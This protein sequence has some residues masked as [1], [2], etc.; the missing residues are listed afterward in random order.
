MSTTFGEAT[1][2]E[3]V[4]AAYKDEIRGKNVVITGV[5]P[6][7]LG[8]GTAAAL[9]PYAK[10]IICT[11]RSV[12]RAKDG[13]KDAAALNG[14]EL[15][16]VE[17]DL[18]SGASIRK[19]AEEIKSFGLPIHV[20]I[21]NAG[22]GQ[23]LELTRT[24]EGFESQIGGN[25][26]GHYLFTSL[27]FPS[28]LSPKTESFRPRIINLSSL[29]I[30]WANGLRADDINFEKR[31]EEYTVHAAYAQSKT[32]NIYFS[33]S[34]AEKYGKEG[35]LSYSV[36]PGLIR[37]T[38]MGGV[39]SDQDLKNIGL[40]DANDKPTVFFK[41]IPQG[42]ATSIYAAFSPDIVEKNGVFLADNAVFPVAQIPESSKSDAD[43]EL[44]WKSSEEGWGIKFGA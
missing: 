37:G 8:A 32:A 29:A 2:A 43:A 7:S 33:K 23:A 9:A 28:L 13:A 6:S 17:L 15:R 41:T 24:A 27:L 3:E 26:Y 10:T 39:M 34:L 11:A 35:V 30:I 4:A 21:N 16:Y 1:T 25:H 44:L 22:L 42:A 19:A 12:A 38:T 20:L 40:I 31:P 14:A 5:S 36:H 18:T